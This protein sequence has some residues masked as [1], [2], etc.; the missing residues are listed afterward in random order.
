MA[1]MMYFCWS[2]GISMKVETIYWNGKEDWTEIIYWKCDKL[3]E[4]PSHLRLLRKEHASQFW[5]F[6][7]KTFSF[8]WEPTSHFI[9]WSYGT[10]CYN[11]NSSFFH[12]S[13]PFGVVDEF[14]LVLQY[15]RHRDTE[16]NKDIIIKEMYT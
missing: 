15:K 1:N 8:T 3:R 5:I 11:W 6:L 7:D 12:E 13:G 9:F 16:K 4:P 14:I 2:L 10:N